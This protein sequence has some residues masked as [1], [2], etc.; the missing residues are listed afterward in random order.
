MSSPNTKRNPDKEIEANELYSTPTIA[1]ETFYKQYPEVFDKFNVFYDPCDGMGQISDYL[2][3]IGKKVY[4]GD[5]VDYK[6]KL[7]FKGSFLEAKAMPEDVDCIVFNPP[8]T[9]TEEFVD[10]ALE[11]CPNLV[12]FNRLTTI[13]S[14]S[15]SDKLAS[16]KWPMDCFYVFGFRVSCPKGINFEPTANSVCY[17]WSTFNRY[18]RDGCRLKWIVKEK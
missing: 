14:I 18:N 11:L 10:N 7:D 13:E 6:G 12:M 16:G 3:S 1:L 2:E 5:I 8:F 4:R 17:S 15:R 9:M